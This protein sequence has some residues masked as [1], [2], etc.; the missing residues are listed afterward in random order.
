[1]KPHR[2]VSG[3]GTRRFFGKSGGGLSAG[4]RS[5]IASTATASGGPATCRGVLHFSSLHIPVFSK[6]FII[7]STLVLV[8][9]GKPK[10]MNK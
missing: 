1:M 2:C 3:Y 9:N 5:V 7:D 8:N 6:V 4:I 10:K